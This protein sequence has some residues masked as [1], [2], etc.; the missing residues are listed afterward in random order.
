MSRRALRSNP[1]TRAG[2]W[3]AAIIA[4][5]LV[6]CGVQVQGGLGGHESSFVEPAG[7]GGAG[8]GGAGQGGA[9][10]G[11]GPCTNAVLD[12]G[13]AGGIVLRTLGEIAYYTTTENSIIRADL[14]SGTMTIL[15]ADRPHLGDIAVFDG[16]LYFSDVSGV[17]Q[18][19]E[20]GGTPELIA[21]MGWVSP[22]IAAG[23]TGLYWL[24]DH[25]VEGYWIHRRAPDG[26]V[27]VLTTDID[28]PTGLS[29][30][31]Q[32]VVYTDPYDPFVEPGAVRV[33]TIDGA[34]STV[35][36]SAR[37][38]PELPFQTEDSIYWVERDTFDGRIAR[39]TLDSAKPEEVFSFVNQYPVAAATDGTAFF[40][41]VMP[42][43]G[44]VTKVV[45]GAFPVADGQEVLAE[46]SGNDFYTAVATTPKRLVWTVQPNV[47]GSPVAGL[48]TLCRDAP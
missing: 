4:S 18:M 40:A 33:V 34:P 9:D 27:T 11:G 13:G 29:V 20:A 16:Q 17:W 25:D 36:A 12:A 5:S 43:D 32:G 15:T 2:H 22:S 46:S 1:P 45:R 42:V 48:R 23:A 47:A 31:P 28:S 14:E 3:G 35:L 38:Y 30:G 24:E 7:G 8:Q 41:I 39:A 26:E 10:A 37:P 6:A 19:P 44:T 21:P